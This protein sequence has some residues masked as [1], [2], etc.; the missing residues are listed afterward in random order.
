MCLF[1]HRDNLKAIHLHSHQAIL[2]IS[3]QDL[4]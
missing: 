2:Y 4:R 3:L 1:E